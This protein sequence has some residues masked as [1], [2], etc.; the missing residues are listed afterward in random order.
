MNGNVSREGI[1]AD[2]EAMRRTGIGGA[3]VFVPSEGI[4]AGPAKY[5]GDEWRADFVFA[6]S[7]CR[8]LGLEL[9]MHNCAG[10]SSSGGPW[11]TPELAMQE[12]VTSATRVGGPARYSGVLP[13]PAAKLEPYRDIAVLA[14]P[15]PAGGVA[16]TMTG[17]AVPRVA[18]VNLT[19]RMAADG[20]LDWDA[21]PGDWIVLRAGFAPNG[22]R[23]HPAPPEGTG[24]ECDKFS[25]R[26]VDAHFNA[27][28]GDL[29]RELGPLAGTAFRNLIIDSYEVGEQG[30]TPG[31][32]REF[33]RLRGYDP[34][35]YLPVLAGQTVDSAGVSNRFLRD[36]RRTFADL[37]A[38]KY[39]GRMAELAHAKG[40]RLGVEP[41]YGPFEGL[42]C[43]G[44]ADIP[45]GEFWIGGGE[46]D[47]CKLAASAGH[48]YGRRIIGAEAF[49]AS[50]E[51]AGWRQH[52]GSM[53]MFG[54]RAFTAGI[55]RLI[56]HSFTHQPWMNRVPGM[57]MGQWGTN[58]GRLN[59]WSEPGAA[60]NTYL[61]RCQFLLQQGRFVADVLYFCGEDA[62]VTLR[63]GNPRLPEGYD[64]DGVNSEVLFDRITVRKGRLVLPEGGSYAVLVA[65]PDETMTPRLLK[66]LG[67]LVRDG[68]TVVGPKP[69]R[70][71][72]LE[73][74]PACD[75][76]VGRLADEVWGKGDGDAAAGHALGRGWVVRGG[77][78]EA[79][80]VRMGMAPDF[81]YRGRGARL[82]YIHRALAGAD[83][84]FVS[85][86]RE[87]VAEVTATF[88]TAG[89]MPELWYPETGA[90]GPAPVWDVVDGRTTVPLRLEP[91]ESVFVVFRRPPLREEHAAL[92]VP[93]AAAAPPPPVAIRRAVYEAEDGKGA[94]DVTGALRKM[95]RDGYL[96][97][98]AENDVLGGDPAPYHFKRLRVEYEAGGAA[99]TVVVREHETLV[100]PEAPAPAGPPAWRVEAGPGGSVEI[101]A[102]EAGGYSVRTPGGKA[103]RVEVPPV[104]GPVGIPGPWEVRFPAGW[105]A[106][107]RIVLEKLISWPESA[108]PGVRYFSGTAAYTASF[109][110][111]PDL[112]QPGIDLVLDLGKV[113]VMAEVSVNG[114]DLGVLWKAPYRV[115]L[116]GAAQAGRN[117]IEIRVTNLWP[118]RLIGDARLPEDCEWDGD[119]LKRWPDWVRE[120]KPSPAGRLTFTTW[121]H[122]RAGSTLLESGLLGPVTVFPARRRSV[123]VR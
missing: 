11:V 87:A 57:T 46:L 38:E 92:V 15:A 78:L 68:A 12:V 8:R 45:M 114:R 70:S 117:L 41:Y 113:A 74:Y 82:A 23:N 119:H 84:Y 81:E 9:G 43:G 24:L 18:I 98:R 122:W 4:P 105:N 96:V 120:G 54:D 66:R 19:R 62:P 106:P 101:V 79:V 107:E 118:N 40:L 26:A 90:T 65:P 123:R 108:D 50:P 39:Y 22:A 91:A 112:V 83:I 48:T 61:A 44:R 86:Q 58:F 89:R 59:T 77:P 14:F 34:V 94:A 80:F 110:L 100:A 17:T 53:K 21:P 109:D 6:A 51:D 111:A 31:F 69:V 72:G 5:L 93:D 63:V 52:P 116:A 13:R 1:T 103:Q 2:L 7:E 25:A 49:T 104:P 102:R 35:P 56:F 33:L 60:W 85:N 73:G 76:E 42:A 97:V 99:G 47:T 36:L 64:F 55:N 30:W 115:D 71:P 28:T 32:E 3:Q 16:F 10:W 88:R 29:L 121:R 67:R 20:R 27:V 75:A 37:F 95:I